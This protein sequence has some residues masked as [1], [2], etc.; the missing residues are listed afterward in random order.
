[1]HYW[2]ENN[3]DNSGSIRASV[4]TYAVKDIYLRDAR[5]GEPLS[6]GSR[7]L[8][9]VPAADDGRAPSGVTVSG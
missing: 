5:E 8:R 9:V 4:K 1:M 3:F 7:P 6:I 2:D